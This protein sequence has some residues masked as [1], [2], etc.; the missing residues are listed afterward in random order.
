MIIAV[1]ALNFL[2][3]PSV[4]AD[5]TL[6]K[7]Q[8]GADSL[9]LVF[10]GEGGADQDVRT[11]VVK[12]INVALSLLGVI[13]LVLLVLAGF[14]Y[15]LS[16]GNEAKTKEAISH[17]KSAVIGLVIV[18]ASWAIVRYVTVMTDNIMQN[19]VDYTYE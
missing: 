14:K 15:M 19:K 2:V 8:V 13:F 4:Q 9:A 6:L 3:A 11:I 16:E 5:E 17:I 10:G 7:G 18:L 12:V 1:A